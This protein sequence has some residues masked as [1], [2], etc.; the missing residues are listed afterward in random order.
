MPKSDQ[1]SDPSDRPLRC[2]PTVAY[3]F[4]RVPLSTFDF[5]LRPA[6]TVVWVDKLGMPPGT[7]AMAIAAAKSVDLFTGFIIGAMTDACRTRWGR[8]KP[9]IAVLWPICTFCM[10]MF[11]CAPSMGFVTGSEATAAPLWASI[12]GARHGRFIAAIINKHDAINIKTV[13]REVR[14]T[15][16]DG[17]SSQ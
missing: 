2:L 6:R 4:F 13:R 9:F 8:R 1:K 17:Y 7:Q 5:T 11:V 14:A 12:G 15:P 3:S 10:I 16:I